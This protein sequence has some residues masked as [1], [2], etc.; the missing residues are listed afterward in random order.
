MAA[1][2]V[3]PRFH[4]M[5]GAEL[6]QWVDANPEHVNDWDR[7]EDGNTPL[8]T[9]AYH[10]KNLALLLWL[11]NEKGADV[12]KR[13]FDGQTPFHGVRSLE[14]LNAL[15]DR[16]A[17]PTALDENNDSPLICHTYF[18]R[19]NIM[20]HLLKDPHV[21]ATINVQRCDGNTA[22]H[23][24]CFREDEGS[25]TSI[26]QLLLQAGANPL[27]INKQGVTPLAVLQEH[28]P[29][30]TTTIAL[31][32]QTHAAAEVTFLLV[33]ARRLIVASASFTTPPYLQGRVVRGE[34]L[35]RVML[36]PR[37][38]KSRTNKRRKFRSML[39]FLFGMTGGPK[40][41]GMPQDAFRDVLMDL[42]M[43]VWDPLRKGSG[44]GTPQQT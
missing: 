14:T 24:A 12:N 9:A 8:Y 4:I 40:G 41:Q 15:L 42:L 7:D 34:S 27:L 2:A 30:Y 6:R 38:G 10:L 3:L 23:F 20:A 22:L 11:L 37:M 31:L 33:K 16:G 1:A 39:C 35:P 19:V 44:V 13:I 25:T 18:R 36:A 17:D 43:P 32:E 26:V 28:H 21:R 5:T 29:A